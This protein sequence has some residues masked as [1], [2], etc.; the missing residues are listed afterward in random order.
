MTSN[1]RKEI[2]EVYCKSGCSNCTAGVCPLMQ[3]DDAKNNSGK[4]VTFMEAAISMVPELAKESEVPEFC[5]KEEL[6]AAGLYCG[7]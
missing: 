3:H 7:Y 1:E 5:T 4:K 2:I 6:Q